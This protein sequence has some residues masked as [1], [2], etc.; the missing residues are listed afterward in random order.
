M[1]SGIIIIAVTWLVC[2]GLAG[3]FWTRY[4]VFI[5]DKKIGEIPGYTKKERQRQFVYQIYIVSFILA[6]TIFFGPL[7]AIPAVITIVASIGLLYYTVFRVMLENGVK[8]SVLDDLRDPTNLWVSDV[9]T[10]DGSVKR[11]TIYS[12]LIMYPLFL[13]TISIIGLIF[14]PLLPVMMIF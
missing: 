11:W 9:E 10:E 6:M 4:D 14:H 8:E 13:I 3:Y 7:G 1:L 5:Q 12:A 2:L